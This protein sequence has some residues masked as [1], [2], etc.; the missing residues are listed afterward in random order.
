MN[1]QNVCMKTWVLKLF[2]SFPEKMPGNECFSVKVYLFER[3][4]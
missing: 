1:P 3:T 2:G 4:A